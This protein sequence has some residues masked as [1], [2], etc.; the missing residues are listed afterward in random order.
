MFWLLSRNDSRLKKCN[1]R[2]EFSKPQREPTYQVTLDVLKLSPCYPAFL[3]T[4]EVPEI[5]ISVL[6][7]LTKILLNHPPMKKWF[8]LSRS[9]GTLASVI[10]YLKSIQIKCTSPGEHLLLS[11]IGESLG[12]HQTPV[13]EDEPATKPKRAKKPEPAKQVE[14]AK[15]TTLAKKSYTMKTAGVVIRDTPS[16]FVSKKKAPAK[17]DRGKGMDL[18]SNVALL[19]AAQLK[20][21]LKKSKQDTHMLYASGSSDGVGSQP[22]VPNELQDKTTGINEGIGTILG[23]PDVPK[24]QSDIVNKSWG[25]SGDDDDDSNNNDSD[26]VSDDDGNDDAS[27]DERTESDDDQNE[28][29]NEEEYKE[30]YVHTPK[31]YESTDDENEHMDEKDYEELYKYVNVR[32]KDAEHGE[33]EKGDEEMGDAG[34]DNVTQEKTYDQDENDAHVTLTTVHDTQKTEVPLQSS[35]VS[36]DFAT[37]FLNLDNVSL[38][39]TEINSMMNIDVCHEES[40]SQTPSLLTIPELFELKQA[41][42]SAQLLEA[43]KSQIPAMVDAHLGTRLRDYI[44]KAF[45][46]YIVE[47]M[48]KAQDEKK[49]YIDLIEK[50]VKDII[51]NEV[52][53]QLPQILPKAVS[54]F[55]T[56]VIKSI[57]T[58]SLKN[59]VLAKSSS[60]PQSTYEAATSLTEFELK[61]ILLDKMQKSQ[62]Y[63]GAKEHEELYDGP[64][65]S[66][67]L[68]KDLY[69]SYGKAYSLKR[70]CED[71]DKDEDPP[72]RSDQRLKR[73]KT[74]K[75]AEP[76]TG[77]KSKES[78]SSSSK[79]TKSQPKSSGK[80]AQAEESVFEISKI[81]QA[82]KPPLSFDEL[83]STPIDLLAYVMN[84]LKIDNLTQEHVVG[85][86]F[87]L[88][89]RTCRSRVE[90]EYNFEECYKAVTDRLDWNNPKGKEYT[91]DLSKPLPLIMD[92]GLQVVPVDFFIN[93]NLEYLSGGSSSKK[94]TTSTTKTKAAKY[95]SPGIKDMVPSL[96][97]SVKVAYNRYVVWEITHWGPKQQRF[98][99]FA[100]NR[101]SKHDVYSKE[102]IIAV[103]KVKVMK[104]YGYGY[105]EEIE[106]QRADQ[107]LYKFKESDFSRLHLHDIEDML[108]L[109][110]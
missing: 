30:E 24:D 104:W 35:S 85:P 80:S 95:D 100:S 29:D 72:A 66:Y 89:K 55:A 65:K 58:E 83:M 4:A 78:K 60:Q 16:V 14:T 102:I 90:L 98:Y 71:K 75:E 43:I 40:S 9:L 61:K 93:N 63:R 45:R 108:L 74:R 21:I 59:I 53:T 10:C 110:V 56:P 11:S 79:G 54:V 87:N 6:D 91:F 2:I 48:K 18:L 86:A 42:Q 31:N 23:V 26:N 7:S 13:L 44:Q 101:K 68:Y 57:V 69:E 109:F 96:W 20:K 76:S 27:D 92:P 49:R 51:N 107:Q 34:H 22:K 17:V 77:P 106:V 105:L 84:N 62:S 28:D 88:L 70:D 5:Y 37:Q 81:A 25:D 3:I 47:F 12:S 103:T 19:E 99:G 52:E 50:S 64:I 46:S 32:L 94:Y 39:D 33:E 15:K 8:H 82:E 67:K 1:A 97:S 36:S 73:Q 41:D 38:A